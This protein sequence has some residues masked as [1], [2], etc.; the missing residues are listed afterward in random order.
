M[1]IESLKVLWGPNYWSIKHRQLIVFLLDL[2]ELEEFPTNKIPN[3]YERITQLIPSLYTHECSEGIP[4]GFFLRVKDGTWMGHVIEH[5][6]LEIQSLAGMDV[7]FGRTR[8]TGTKGHYHVVF[9]YEVEEAGRFAAKAAV[10]I[11]ES[12]V[13]NEP[14]DL[15][16]DITHM[17][18]IAERM[19]LGPTTASIVAEARSRGIPCTRLDDE[20][21][22]Q[23]GYGSNHK[24]I[25]ASISSQTSIIGVELAGDKHRTKQILTDVFV[26]V[27]NGVTI[28]DVENIESAIDEVGMPVVIKPLDGNQGK[29]ATT[30]IKTLSCAVDAFHRAKEFSDKIII[31][32]FIEGRDFRALVV[33]YKFIA[34]ALRTPAAVIGDGEHTITQLIDIVNEDPRRGNGHCNVLTKITVDEA[35]NE[36]LARHQYTLDTVLP[37]GAELW[38]KTTANLSTGGTSEDVTEK[39]HSCNASLFERIARTMGLDICGIDVMAPDLSVPITQNGGAVIEVN[40]AP[41]LRMHLEPTTGTPRNVAVPIIDMLF[42]GDRNGR[43]PIV[44]ITGT[45]GKTTTS[46]ILSQMVQQSGLNTGL[47]T[48]DGIYINRELIFKGDCS[49]PFS[50]QVLLRDPIVEFAVLECARGGILR[51]GLG[52]DECDCAIVTNVAE[53]HLGMDGIDTLEKLA[54]L[55]SV[56]PETV[57]KDG[58]AILNADDDLVYAMKDKLSCKVALFSLH[59]DNIRIEQHCEGGGIAAISDEGYLLIREGKKLTVID[60]VQNVTLTYGGK[61]KFNVANVLAAVLAAYVNNIS[62]DNVRNTLRNFKT[63]ADVTPG[64]MNEFKFDGFSVMVDYAHNTHGLKAFGEFVTAIPATK[65]VGVITGVGDRRNEDII[66]LAEEAAR[67]FDEIVIRM[68]EDL[69]GRTE[70]EIASLLGNGIQRAAPGKKVMYFSNEPDAL[71]HVV[72]H[73]EVGSFTVIFADKVDWVCNRLKEYVDRFSRSNQSMKQTA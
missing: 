8:G 38:L 71:D 10:R 64:R 24:K 66:A 57:K 32:R 49:G 19:K 45:N 43:I 47:T 63:P 39:V 70:F 22:V 15:Q 65:R 50:A 6:A 5:I 36:I 7:G 35:T 34:A 56:V 30:N 54:R 41:G 25:E 26:P 37:E 4:G 72:H 55:K 48:T 29:G 17:K 52:F 9:S 44:A 53:D 23:L 2:E 20:A 18:N 1:K 21:Y 40:A 42:P 62:L 28:S 11:A 68:D 27:P 13:R 12:L 31:E 46:R 67:I 69:R 51:S 59:M 16:A 3:F 60:E 58:Y 33:N 61:A 73:A 14:Y